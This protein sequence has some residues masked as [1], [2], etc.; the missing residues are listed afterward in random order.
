MD[1]LGREVAKA[2]RHGE[3]L[4]V[5]V[6]G[7]E[8][9]DELSQ[10]IDRESADAA[11]SRVAQQLSDGVGNGSV[12]RLGSGEF[13]LV[14]AGATVDDAEALL[15]ALHSADHDDRI[16]GI[17]LSAGITELAERDDAQSALGRAEHALW[18]AKQAGPGTI[19]VAV[20]GRRTPR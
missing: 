5:L 14:L 17:T 4:A 7:L 3:S 20:P 13:A 18:Q 1:T 19:V 11:L 8:G 12:H 9:L 10:R 2:R 15:G 16:D 6:V